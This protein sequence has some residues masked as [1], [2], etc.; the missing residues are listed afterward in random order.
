MLDDLIRAAE[1]DDYDA[2][3]EL[4]DIAAADPQ[5]LA[6]HLPRLLERGV[7]WPPTLY[8]GAGPDVVAQAVERVDGGRQPGQLNHLLLILAHI[9]DPA[10]EAALRRWEEQPPS[11]LDRLHLSP[12]GYAVTAG[13]TVDSEGRRRDLCAPVAYRLVM[14]PTA[15][16]AAA[17]T[18]PWCESPLMTLLDLDPA[19]PRVAG[20]LAHTGWS[21]RL[22]FTTCLGCACYTTLY[23]RVTPDGGSTWAPENSAPRHL[24]RSTEDPPALLPS[25][26]PARTSAYQASAWHPE[27]STLGGH[28]DWIQ[29]AEH[30]DCLVCGQTMDYVALVGGADLD[31][32][33][34]AHYL[35]LHAPC[36]VTAVTYQQS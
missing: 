36:G 32:G 6:P 1:S 29:D 26:G 22:L 25:V 4:A 31:S 27:G 17:P 20:V 21:G 10:A 18:C 5:R 8:R 24:H 12:L 34:G 3:E 13:W 11:G 7:L 16:D 23:S 33:E 19:D 35:H 30:P 9:R 28:P 14:T 2:V 15:P